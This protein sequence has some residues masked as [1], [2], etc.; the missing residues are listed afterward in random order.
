MEDARVN[1]VQ[2]ARC[3]VC[4][5]RDRDMA[6][7]IEVRRRIDEVLLIGGSYRSALVAVE[8]LVAEWPD[9]E[10]PTYAA[11]RNHAKKHLRVD[12]V[13]ARMVME[14]Q[15][16]AD[17][18][19]PEDDDGSILTPAAVLALILEKGF[20]SMHDLDL[21]PTVAETITAARSLSTIDTE[22]LRMQ[23]RQALETN[24]AL[25]AIIRERVP[26][27]DLEGAT[28]SSSSSV[29]IVPEAEVNRPHQLHSGPERACEI[30]GRT[31]KSAQGLKVHIARM[32]QETSSTTT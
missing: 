16:R 18:I 29:V 1:Y 15:A 28:R 14:R 19:D 6:E 12:E 30:C 3:R 21:R 11:V 31:A 17:G 5:T 27:A 13:M 25:I 24:S 8:H 26:D 20:R 23:L 32:H 22:R 4:N 2:A 10:R 7:T 9:P